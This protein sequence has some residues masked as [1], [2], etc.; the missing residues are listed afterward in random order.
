LFI[1]ALLM[2][3]IAFISVVRDVIP[4]IKCCCGVL[5]TFFRGVLSGW[6]LAA[7]SRATQSPAA[8]LQLTSGMVQVRV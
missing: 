6:K 8:E 2:G 1:D 5:S 3:R 4:F 7:L